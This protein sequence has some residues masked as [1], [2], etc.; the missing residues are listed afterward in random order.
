M[1]DT[2]DKYFDSIVEQLNLNFEGIANVNFN[3]IPVNTI[4]P[5]TLEPASATNPAP[6]PIIND[7]LVNY[8]IILVSNLQNEIGDL[9]SLEYNINSG[10]TILDTDKITLAD[11]NTDNKQL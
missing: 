9:L 7:Y 6:N 3:S 5:T 4:Q 11:Y 2:N 1:S 8:E 10:D